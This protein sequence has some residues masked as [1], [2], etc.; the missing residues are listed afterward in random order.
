MSKSKILCLLVLFALLIAVP[1]CAK[2]E[3]GGIDE[4]AEIEVWIDA[5]REESAGKFIEPEP[6]GRVG[7]VDDDGLWSIA[8][9]DPVLEQRGRRLA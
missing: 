3:E 6:Q 8:A 7:H 9:K 4:S 5:A 2:K 1:A